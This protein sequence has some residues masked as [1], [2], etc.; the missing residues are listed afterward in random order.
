MKKNYTIIVALILISLTSFAQPVLNA[1]DFPTNVYGTANQ[2]KYTGNGTGITQGSAGPNQVWDFSTLTTLTLLGTSSSVP[3]ATVPFANSFPTANIASKFTG[4]GLPDYSLRT[5]SPTTLELI[6]RS[7]GSGG[8]VDLTSNPDIY[9]TFPYTYNTLINHIQSTPYTS[10][11]S[12]TYDAYGTVSTPFGSYTNVIRQ[13]KIYAN[14]TEYDWFITNPGFNIM[15]V[16]I[17]PNA[18]PDIYFSQITS[19]SVN[20]NTKANLVMIYPNPTKDVLH[21]DLQKE[22]SG[23]ITDLTGKTLMN[24]TTK[25]IDVSS[26][27]AGIYLLDIVSEDKHFVS[28]IVKE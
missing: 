15:T 8:Y 24:V 20:E 12:T 9:F 2:Y 18:N 3:V 1:S 23:K 4:S 13:K 19:L 28:K 11:H 7:N 14:Y 27:V 25:D 6:A 21:I 26:L 17:F 5:I 22:L 16:V 10:T